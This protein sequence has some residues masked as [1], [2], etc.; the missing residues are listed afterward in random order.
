MTSSSKPT[1]SVPPPG[2]TPGVGV[3]ALHSA[4]GARRFAAWTPARCPAAPAPTRRC[5]ARPTRP[6][7]ADM[8]RR[9]RGAR[10]PVARRAPV[11]LPGRLPR[12]PGRARGLQAGL[13]EPGDGADR[14]ADR[15]LPAT[16]STRCSSS[17]RRPSRARPRSWRA[18]S[19]AANSAT[20]PE[21][22]ATVAQ[23]AID[24]LLLSA[25]HIT[26]RVHPDD[27]ALVALGAGEALAARGARL[28]ADADAGARRLHRRVR[29]RRDRRHARRRAGSAPRAALGCESAWD[30]RRRRGRRSGRTD[31]RR[32]R[33]TEP[34][35][36][37]DAATRSDWQRFLADLQAFAAEP[38]PLEIAGHAGAR[39]RPGARGRRHPRAGRLGLRGAH[40]G[41][42]RRCWPKWSASRATAPT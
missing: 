16:S 35:A 12:R 31:G 25:R 18:R 5:A 28:V 11:G 21:L 40:A 27:H 7:D 26:L 9:G 30:G 37:T 10:A 17:S 15:S 38:I 6:A 39:G 24:T 3:C 14:R 13:C 2:G 42:A 34:P 41:P 4:R 20:R 36:A 23:E 29:H 22:V 33:R 19:C 1:R 8:R 32:G